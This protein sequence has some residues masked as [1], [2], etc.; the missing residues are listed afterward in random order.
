M[1]VEDGDSFANIL[2]HTGKERRTGSAGRGGYKGRKEM[3][4]CW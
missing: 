2:F 3:G 1:L 4:E